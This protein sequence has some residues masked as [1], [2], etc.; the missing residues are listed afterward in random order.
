LRETERTKKESNSPPFVSLSLS[1]ERLKA[2]LKAKKVPPL[3]K[4]GG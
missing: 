3:L 2:E 1:K 4:R